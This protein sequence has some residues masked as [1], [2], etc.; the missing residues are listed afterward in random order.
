MTDTPKEAAVPPARSVRRYVAGLLVLVVLAGMAAAWFW[1]T[2]QP[3]QTEA[4]PHAVV[5][6]V[7]G[8]G[9]LMAGLIIAVI[10]SMSLAD[11]VE[12]TLDGLF[13]VL[14]AI[15]KGLWDFVCGLFGWD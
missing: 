3:P 1:I 14:G 6:V 2:R 15:L 9:A 13:A 10:R 4:G 8:A 5:V 7:V 11:I 12:L